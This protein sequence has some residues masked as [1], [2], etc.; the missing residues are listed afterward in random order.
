MNILE[1]NCGTGEDATWLAAQGHHV[2]ATDASPE[3]IR[4]AQRKTYGNNT[5]GLTF[6]TCAFDQLAQEFPS[7]QFD[8][9]FSNFSGLNCLD[10]PALAA[11]QETL[12]TLLKPNG[13]LVMVLFGKYCMTEKIYFLLKNDQANRQRRDAPAVVTLADGV[14]QVTCYYAAE[15]IGQLFTKF[16]MLRKRAVG[17]FILPS[18]LERW[19]QRFSFLA[20]LIQVSEEIFSA[21]PVLADRGDH[22]FIAMQKRTEVQA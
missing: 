2:T 1:I 12:F 9:I 8:L 7:G 18:Y 16:R 20:P 5:A 21:W 3:M 6:K 14:S 13:K 22:I 11:L 17:L 10:A 19:M 15:E 4:V